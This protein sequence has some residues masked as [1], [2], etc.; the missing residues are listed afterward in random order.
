MHPDWPRAFALA[1]NIRDAGEA[2]VAAV[3]AGE[4]DLDAAH[5]QADADPHTGRVFAVKVYEAVAGIGKVKARRTMADIGLDDD[6]TLG[7]VPVD[8][9]DEISARF[10]EIIAAAG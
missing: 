2:I 6:V 5:A 9:R 10:D 1:A 4:I 3:R 8:K 7:G